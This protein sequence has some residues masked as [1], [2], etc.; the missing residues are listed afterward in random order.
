MGLNNLML[1]NAHTH[2]E[3]SWASELCPEPPGSPFADWIYGLV[4]RWQMF[5]VE[6][7]EAQRTRQAV[8]DGITQL[9]EAGVT[10]VGDISNTGHSI[11]PLLASGLGGTVYL[12][13][14]GESREVG[15]A[16]FQQ[17]CEMLE[18]YRL[19]ERNGLRIGLTPHTPY[20]VHPDV[21]RE[22][23]VYCLRENVPLCIHVAESPFENEALTDG[24]GPIFDLQ[25]RFGNQSRMHVPGRRAISYLET[26][27][28]LDAAPLLVHMVDV[29]AAELD[30]VASYNAKVVHCPRS[31][32]LLQ[33][34]QM[35]LAQMLAKGISVAL[36][37]DSLSS[38]PSLNVREEVETAV[39]MHHP[40]VTSQQI[41]ELLTNTAVL[42]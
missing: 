20:T 34:G 1:V 17:A 13:I 3:L 23:A 15:M 5:A 10:H 9:I 35:P 39:S 26:L 24:T 21:L 6:G 19:L 2:L 42:N 32:Q 18:K 22:T 28:V 14:I 33:C 41:D 16:R 27:G 31:N 25:A 36:G 30:I 4:M 40:H 37:T 38:S 7:D 12:E 8:E 29:Q 11:E